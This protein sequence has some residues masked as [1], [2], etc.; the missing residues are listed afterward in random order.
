MLISGGAA[1]SGHFTRHSDFHSSA[2]V[3]WVVLAAKQHLEYY[4]RRQ[5]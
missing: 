1:A 5:E 4:P 3:D 2:C